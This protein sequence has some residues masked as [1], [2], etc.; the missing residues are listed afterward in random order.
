MTCGVKAVRKGLKRDPNALWISTTNIPWMV[1]TK[2]KY[3]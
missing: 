1:E 3:M 2:A